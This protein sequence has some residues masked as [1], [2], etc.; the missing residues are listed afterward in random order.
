M[1]GRSAVL[2]GGRGGGHRDRPGRSAGAGP[3]A[4]RRRALAL[5]DAARLASPRR[6][7]CRRHG[8]RAR[9]AGDGGV[10]PFRAAAR[11]LRPGRHG[12]GERRARPPRAGAT[13]AGARGCRVRSGG[14]HRG[15]G[16]RG[17]RRRVVGGGR[18]ALAASHRCLAPRRRPAAGARPRPRPARACAQR[19]PGSRSGSRS[20]PRRRRG[21]GAGARGRGGA[22]GRLALVRDHRRRESRCGPRRRHRGGRHGPHGRTVGLRRRMVAGRAGRDPPR[23]RGGAARAAA[24]ARRR[25]RAR[26]RRGDARLR[27]GDPRPRAGGAHGAAGAARARRDGPLRRPAVAAGA[28]GLGHRRRELRP[29]AAPRDDRR[30]A[31]RARAGRRGRPA[32]GA[33]RGLAAGRRC[34]LGP[35]S[36]WSR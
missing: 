14:L 9:G 26:R 2:G 25:R 21:R 13:A 8:R 16:G 10:G 24:H 35:C 32:E 29:L 20:R 31:G 36:V 11:R 7:D 23:R 33:R 17:A 5:Q 18:D 3:L 28:R 6:R 1:A 19:T 27:R 15:A 12:R 34:R 30:G 4:P 22:G